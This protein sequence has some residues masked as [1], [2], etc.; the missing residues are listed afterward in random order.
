MTK[1]KTPPPERHAATKTVTS[2]IL[3]TL[4]DIEKR[5]D[6]TILYACESGSRAWGFE[7]PDSD[8]DVRF[9]YMHPLKWYLRIEQE[10]DV[11][12]VPRDK[13]MD[14][15]GWELRKA[16]QLLRRSNPTLLEWLDSPVIY[17]ENSP[18][19]EKLRTLGPE[20]F[21]PVRGRNHYLSMARRNFRGFVH[22]DTVRY[23]K[24][25]YVL[26]PLLA[27]RWID[28]RNTMPPTRFLT[29]LDGTISDPEL[30]SEIKNLM[31]LK[32]HARE[33]AVGPAQPCLHTFI[34]EEFAIMNVI[35]GDKGVP[36]G[37]EVLDRLFADTVLT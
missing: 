37:A 32:A 2:Q 18:F 33:T 12:E 29:L 31:E 26:R 34:E 30:L 10:R 4:K 25:F 28:T 7:S 6:V 36:T 5:H 22:A 20:F 13:D 19:A 24:Y 27:V 11:I 35:P 1:K 16:L 14:I 3:S 23:K 15:N 9:L 8:Y 21:S 17:H